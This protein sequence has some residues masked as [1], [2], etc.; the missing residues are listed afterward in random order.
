MKIMPPRNNS[1]PEDSTSGKS[2]PIQ[3]LA[4]ALN[5]LM[6]L[7][8]SSPTPMQLDTHFQLPKFSGHMNG[9]VIDSWVIVYP[10]ISR[11]SQE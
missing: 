9:E 4:L 7:Q 6:R 8:Q 2:S 10:L 5:E 1:S 11:P 3:D